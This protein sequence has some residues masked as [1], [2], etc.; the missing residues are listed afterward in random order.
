MLYMWKAKLI[1]LS[2]LAAFALTAC[3]GGSGSGDGEVLLYEEEVSGGAVEAAASYE[4]VTVRR[5]DYQEIYSDTGELEYTDIET[6]YIDEEDAVLDSIKVKRNQRVQKGD[7]LAVF[8]LETSKTKLEKQRLV[9]E[10]ARAQFESGLGSLNNSLSQAEQ[11]YKR[12]SQA[13]DKKMK[14]LEIKKIRKEIEAYKKGEKELLDQEK[15]Y[16]KLVRMQ[17][18]TNLVAKKGGVVTS[19]SRDKVGEEIDSSQKIVEFRNNDKWLLKVKDPESMLRYNMSVSVRL[20]RNMKNYEHEVPGKVVTASD[21]TGTD[22][23]DSGGDKVV[24]I[25]VRDADK[26]KYDFE[27]NNIYIHAVSFEVKD[28]LMID[29]RAV[30]TES[31]GFTN[32][33]FV[34]VLED[35]NLH[36]RFIV[37]NYKNEKDYL[38][39]QGLSEGQTLAIVE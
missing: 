34:W 15:E 23:T 39:A 35:G 16:A 31:V 5:E 37:S 17:S 8:H 9:N 7:V 4:T 30:D 10:Q 13:A 25:D 29:A 27:S 2:I 6:V 32:K 14:S 21:L 1:S 26:R 36:K 3:G 38:V 12:L 33:S 11:E 24:Y 20:G 18:K 22:E 28:A 19:V